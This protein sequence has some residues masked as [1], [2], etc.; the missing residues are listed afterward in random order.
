MKANDRITAKFPLLAIFW[1]TKYK[2]TGRRKVHLDTSKAT[3]EIKELKPGMVSKKMKTPSGLQ[4][5]EGC[6]R[7]VT[8]LKLGGSADCSGR[9]HRGPAGF[10]SK[11]GK[12]ETESVLPQL[13]LVP[14]SK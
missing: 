1:V 10:D 4:K 13:V 12:T 11:L 2:L 8:I 6:G 14:R 3:V 5:G 7:W 9:D